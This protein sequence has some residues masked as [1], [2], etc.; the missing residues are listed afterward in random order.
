MKDTYGVEVKVGDK[1]VY[2]TRQSCTMYI[3]SATVL[4]VNERSIRVRTRD[5]SWW[6]QREG[7]SEYRDT[8][9]TADNFVI[10]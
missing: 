10:V 6:R 1:I 5:N 7:K 9:L 2:A 3:Y 4:E 8:T